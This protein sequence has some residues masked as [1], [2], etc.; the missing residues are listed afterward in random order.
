MDQAV[1]SLV[2]VMQETSDF[3]QSFNE[4]HWSSWLAKNAE[5]IRKLDFGGVEHLLSAFGGIG[6]INDLVIS[7]ITNHQSPI[8]SH[9]IEENKV[10]EANERLRE[11]LNQINSSAKKLYFEENS[12][13]KLVFEHSDPS[14][15]IIYFLILVAFFLSLPVISNLMKNR[16]N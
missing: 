13:L 16:E 10:S 14:I 3:L 2:K 11:M 15:L 8:N 7:P 5:L 1:E 9:Q 12:N 4:N 6:S